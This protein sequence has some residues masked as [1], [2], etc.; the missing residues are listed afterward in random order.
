MSLKQRLLSLTLIF[1]VLLPL[2]AMGTQS[3]VQ[4]GDKAY[5][6]TLQGTQRDLKK[7]IQQAIEINLYAE[8]EKHRV[9]LLY[10]FFSAS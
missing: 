8:I 4:V 3:G 9:V 7:G 2:I 6:F 5:D 10:F 1:S